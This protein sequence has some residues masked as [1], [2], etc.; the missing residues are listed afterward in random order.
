MRAIYLSILIITTL[1][2]NES[3]AVHLLPEDSCLVR[4][5]SSLFD[6]PTGKEFHQLP[7]GL[8]SMTKKVARLCV[9]DRAAYL[10]LN[11]AGHK[12]NLA[13]RYSGTESL[14]AHLVVDD[15]DD[16]VCA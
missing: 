10:W 16:C 7:P 9:D 13:R 1:Q 3:Y 4:S 11:I 2:W 6:A 15:D 12:D 5:Q 8:D 14:M